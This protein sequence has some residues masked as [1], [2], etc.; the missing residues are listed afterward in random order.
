MKLAARS[1]WPSSSDRHRNGTSADPALRVIDGAV[2][3]H[4][5][6]HGAVLIH[7][8]FAGA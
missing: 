3:Q 2:A 1:T 5:D 4:V 6:H 8:V 7:A